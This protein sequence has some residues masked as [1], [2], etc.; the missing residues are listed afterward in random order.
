MKWKKGLDCLFDQSRTQTTGA[1]ADTLIGAADY[2]PYALNVGIEH[3]SGFVVGMTDVVPR[4]RLF[5]TDF[6]LKC[7]GT[8]PS[9]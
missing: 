2:C 5:E 3:P 1:D 4:G 7:H 6:T 8:T 9:N